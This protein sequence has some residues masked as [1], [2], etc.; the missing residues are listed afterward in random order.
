[1]HSDTDDRHGG[2]EGCWH[3][4]PCAGPRGATISTRG[5]PAGGL[6][7]GRA[8]PGNMETLLSEAQGHALLC[9]ATETS[10]CNAQNDGGTSFEAQCYI[11]Y[12]ASREAPYCETTTF[13]FQIGFSTFGRSMFFVRCHTRKHHFRLGTKRRSDFRL[14]RMTESL[15]ETT[16]FD[17]QVGVSTFGR[18]MFL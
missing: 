6:T 1:M 3:A 13:D 14:C 2:R 17:F 11:P 15:G 12:C 5:W 16:T 18:S 7:A 8:T 9:I 4:G 10:A